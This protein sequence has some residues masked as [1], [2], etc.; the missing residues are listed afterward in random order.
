MQPT[1]SERQPLTSSSD[2]RLWMRMLPIWI[3]S[4]A[5]S[6]AHITRVRRARNKH[7]G[8]NH[9]ERACMHAEGNSPV[10]LT[11]CVPKTPEKTTGLVVLQ[12]VVLGV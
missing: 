6:P 10:R 12:D 5:P 2:D 8:N 7:G 11:D 4:F 1:A 3:S 9:M